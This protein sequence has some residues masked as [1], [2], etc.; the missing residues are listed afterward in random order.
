MENIIIG[1]IVGLLIGIPI[2]MIVED[3]MDII[4]LKDKKKEINENN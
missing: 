1:L 3:T 4:K 2:G